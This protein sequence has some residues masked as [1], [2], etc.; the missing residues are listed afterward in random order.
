MQTT[1]E[2]DNQLI[3]QARLLT[4]MEEISPLIHAGLGALI[5]HA[6]ASSPTYNAPR[7]EPILQSHRL[8]TEDR[9]HSRLGELG[10][11]EPQ[12][13]SVPRRRPEP[14]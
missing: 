12:L 10:G 1:I 13:R 9:A 5:E 3:E 2:I 4:G 14:S 11:S 7:I 8:Q 6:S